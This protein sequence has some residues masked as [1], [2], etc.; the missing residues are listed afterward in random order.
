MWLLLDAIA[1]VGSV[2][3]SS[4]GKCHPERESDNGLRLWT[5]AEASSLTITSTFWD[6]VRHTW[7]SPHGK[8]SRIDHIVCR[9]RHADCAQR[10]WVASDVDLTFNVAQDHSMVIADFVVPEQQE[11]ETLRERS[12]RIDKRALAD[13]ICVSALPIPTLEFRA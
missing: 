8:G 12:F 1:R 13:P 4:V 3:S 2:R 6:S 7:H 11:S 9:Q 5:F 10:C